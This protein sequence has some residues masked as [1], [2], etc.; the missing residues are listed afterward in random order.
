MAEIGVGDLLSRQS[1]RVALNDDFAL[2]QGCVVASGS[3]RWTYA[4]IGLYRAELFEGCRP[5]RFALLPLLQRAMAVQRLQGEIYGGLWSDVGT[6][7]RLAALQ[8]GRRART[9]PIR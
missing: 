5:G 2:E 1:L 7:E 6:A 8:Q 3:P 9:G 4:G